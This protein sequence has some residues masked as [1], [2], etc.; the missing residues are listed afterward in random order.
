MAKPRPDLPVLLTKPQVAIYLNASEETVQQLINTGRLPA[1]RFGPRSTR[2]YK[3]DVDAL[4]EPVVP[5][6]RRQA[7]DE[8]A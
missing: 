6:R 4:L 5:R 8:V 2:I 1:V 7:G 3:S